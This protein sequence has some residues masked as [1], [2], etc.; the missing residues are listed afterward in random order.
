MQS[1]ES[2]LREYIT[3]EIAAGSGSPPIEDS[4][5]LIESGILDSLGVLKLVIFVEGK[6]GLKIAP[7]EVIPAN[8]ETV[9]ALGDFVR[10]KAPGQ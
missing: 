3:K 10:R 5:K 9:A 4:T 2:V 1:V 7:T 6:F 8:F